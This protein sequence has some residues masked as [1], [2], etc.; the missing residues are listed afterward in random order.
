[1]TEPKKLHRLIY[2]SRM[3]SACRSRLDAELPAILAS[4]IRGNAWRGITGVLIAHRGW[5]VQALE[6]DTG[7]V[8]ATYRAISNDHRHTGSTILT[9]G[10]ATQRAFGRW[11]MCARALGG[12][13]AA[14]IG[15]LDRRGAFDPSTYPEH[16][17][18]RLLLAVAEVHAGVFDS[19]QA[20]AAPRAKAG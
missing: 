10:P 5:F 11:S 18:M 8:K 17:V 9:E 16:T 14:I 3:T 6:G 20:P 4:A 7:A 15:E 1:M 13:D 2:A 12:V 19:Q